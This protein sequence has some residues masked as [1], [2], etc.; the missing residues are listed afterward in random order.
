MTTHLLATKLFIPP[1][2]PNLVPRSRLLE[3]LNA[4][5][6]RKVTL[7][8]A[9]A[10]F[11]KTSLVTEWLDNV[12]LDTTT[13]NRIAWLS[14]DEDDNDLVRFLTYL[15]TALNQA[16]GAEATFGKG[17]LSMLQS[18]QPPSTKSI[19]TELI[20]EIAGVTARINLVLDDYHLIDTQTIHDALAFLIEN[21][22][23]QMCLIIAT[24]EDPLLP[25]ARLRAKD[26]LTELRA[27]DLR[28]VSSEAAEFLNQVMGLNLSPENIAALENRTEGWI[29]G[30][31]LAAISLKGQED[32]TDFLK[33]FSGNHRLVLDYLIE[34]VLG[35]QPQSIQHFLLQTSILNRL[36]GSLCDALTSG[37]NGQQVLETLERANLFIVSLDNE[38]HWYRYHHLFADLLSNRLN[39]LFHDRIPELH[40]RASSWYENEGFADDAIRHAQVAGDIDRVAIIIEEHWQEYVHRGELARLI[41]L[42]DSLGPE[43]TKK[44]AI[45]SLAY[46]W[47]HHL[48]GAIDVIPA[49]INDIR[50]VLGEESENVQQP[51]PLA[52]IPSAIEVLEAIISLENNHINKAKKHAEKAISL[53]PDNVNVANRRL[54][55]GAA[56]FRLAQ[57]HRE[58]G[59]IDQACTALLN[60]LEMLKAS[61]DYFGTANT[62]L[63]IVRLYQESN[64][65]QEAIILCEDTLAFIKEHQWENMSPSGIVNVI[66]A[67]L[68]ADTGDYVAAR[69]NL[70]IGRELTEQISSQQIRR[71]VD[72]VEEKLDDIKPASQPLIEPLSERELDV[73]HLLNEGFTN[74]DIATRLFLSLNTVKVHTRNIYGKLGVNNRMQAVVKAKNLGILPST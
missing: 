54:L 9:P 51:T 29:V 21:Q 14:L 57:A 3:K 67:G 11:G 68:Q 10:G 65:T 34:E 27:A 5:M 56:G 24:R 62:V 43:I 23:Q 31:Q 74:Q 45:L 20:N 52:L 33:T 18:S 30:L 16:E 47:V 38:R 13:E 72:R 22:P 36:T 59:E 12:R 53:I 66:L 6:H 17:A 42:L 55:Q 2:R 49:Y 35:Q 44:S 50:E 69:K 32:T 46:G 64:K 7:I 39:R 63:Q 61:D 4:G 15:V 28:F 70:E 26:Q 71:L 73:L 1:T 58:L 48:T 37:D 40:K 8:S 25:L 60:V 19:L 41:Y